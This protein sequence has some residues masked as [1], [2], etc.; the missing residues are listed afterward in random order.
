MYPQDQIWKEAAYI[1]YHF[2][3]MLDDILA[4]EHAERHIWLREIAR[5]NEQINVARKR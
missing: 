2:H 4:M 5:I 3:W 1:A